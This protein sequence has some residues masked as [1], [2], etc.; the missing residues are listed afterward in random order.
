M[1]E[2][3]AEQPEGKKVDFESALSQLESIVHDL[4]EGQIGLGESLA[5]YEQGVKLLRQ[6]YEMLE[7][8]QRRI[9]LLTGV[10]AEG[11]PIAEPLEDEERS[12]EEKADRRSRP[13]GA[14]IGR[15]RTRGGSA[16][17]ECD[18]DDA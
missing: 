8:A 6:C 17:A 10:D 7:G 18:V 2:E 9:E 3:Q 16:Q 4:E 1:T 5:R 11:R 14:R 15:N 13:E 12:L